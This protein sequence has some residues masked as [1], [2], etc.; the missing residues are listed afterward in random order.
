M[1]SA[2]LSRRLKELEDA[3]V[4]ER[5]PGQG[6]TVEYRLTQAGE[7]LRP[8]IEA[9]GVWGARW[10]SRRLEPHD[11]DPSLLMWDI[12]RRIDVGRLPSDRRTA[13]EVQL[14][15]AEPARRRWWLVV[16][17]GAVDLCLK[18]PG[19]D[20]DLLVT[21]EL[22]SLVDVWSGA[23]AME[24]E[25]RAKRIVFDGPPDLAARFRDSLK[26]SV[27]REAVRSRPA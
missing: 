16:E 7:E 24:D 19:Y 13:V 3:G 6:R 15:D 10:V 27:F 26:L 22:R 18:D 9:L 20:I 14:R 4:I 8:I 11:Y 17:D 21:A 23:R 1:S 12:R 25:I 5:L 2:L